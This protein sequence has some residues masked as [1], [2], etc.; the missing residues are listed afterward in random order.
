MGKAFVE[1]KAQSTSIP[2]G[3]TKMACQAVPTKGINLAVLLCCFILKG[4]HSMSPPAIRGKAYPDFMPLQQLLREDAM[5]P[6]MIPLAS[7]V[8]Q[9]MIR[10][11]CLEGVVR[12][13]ASLI[14]KSTR[15][16]RCRLRSLPPGSEK[17]RGVV[18][19]G[20]KDGNR[21]GD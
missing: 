8:A 5:S 7:L 9:A 14:G 12:R 19:T 16:F 11:W 20:R 21:G 15:F 17:L 3:K 2:D 6:C 13:R 4:P 10:S 1:A 18:N